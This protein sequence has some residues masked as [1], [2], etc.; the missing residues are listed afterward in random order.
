MVDARLKYC[1]IDMDKKAGARNMF[2]KGVN[3]MASRN[4]DQQGEAA[5][6]SADDQG[7][8]DQD[9]PPKKARTGSLNLRDMYQEILAENEIID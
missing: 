7:Q 9:C 5:G 3:E 6:G 1:F 4:N 2:L 8:E